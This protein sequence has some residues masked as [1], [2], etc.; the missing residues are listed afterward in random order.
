MTR[1]RIV[2]P[3]MVLAVSRRT[4]R[5]YHLFTPD[6]GGQME[7]IFWYSVGYAL[8]K[9]KAYAKEEKIDGELELHAACL[10]S[11]HEH[12]N[13]TDHP[14]LA[15]M[16]Y[17]AFHRA[18]ALGTK[19]FRGWPE[20]VLNKSSTVAHE[21]LTAEALIRSIAYT[22][23]NPVAAFAVRFAKQWPGA[24]VRPEDIGTRVI[25]VARPK[26]Y[27]RNPEIYKDVYEFA[28][29]M[30]QELIDHCGSLE[31]A[32]QAIGDAVRDIEKKAQQE[33][34]KSS[35]R[36][37]GKHRV[38]MMKHTKRASN[39]EV[40]GAINPEFAAGGALRAAKLAVERVR[41]FRAR[42]SVALSYY[43]KGEFENAVFPFG[44]YKM[45]RKHHC[46]C[47]PLPQV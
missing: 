35:Y 16:F 19:A 26:H 1:S 28:L 43:A 14:A 27:F 32:Q 21:V 24:H 40:F 36:F 6:K 2:K 45:V 22:I 7:Q 4:T 9:V 47:E 39:Y 29:V 41:D 34:A 18:L 23:A 31:A 10:M 33:A 44:T 38:L 30:P 15:P 42:Y 37:K 20:E 25:R 3:G 17:E 8:E 11:T 5:R 13:I 46:T 12:C